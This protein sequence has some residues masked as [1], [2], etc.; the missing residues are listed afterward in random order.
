MNPCSNDVLD[1]VAKWFAET[2]T[3]QMQ[4]IKQD[5]QIVGNTHEHLKQQ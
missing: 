5:K 1:K 2:M 3:V 4:L